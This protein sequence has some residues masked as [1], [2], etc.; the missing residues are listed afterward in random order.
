LVSARLGIGGARLGLGL[1][2]PAHEGAD[3]RSPQKIT[4]NWRA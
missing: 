1:E 4:E 3:N 2:F